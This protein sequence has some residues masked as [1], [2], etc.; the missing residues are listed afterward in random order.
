MNNKVKCLICGQEM[1]DLT[2][3]IFRKHG[4]KAEQYRQQFPNSQIRCDSLL[5]LQS[6]RISGDK[7]PAYQHGGKYSPFSEKFVGGTENI[8]EAKKKA[9]E[10]KT[11]DKD[12][13]QLEYWITKTNGDV[14]QAKKLLTERQKTFSL[15]ICIDKYGEEKGK[16]VW[17]NRQEKWHKNYKKSNFSKVSQKL[18]WQM[19]DRLE[20]LENIYFAELDDT[21]KLDTS[22]INHELRLTLDEKVVLPD[23]I[24]V[25]QKK[26]IEFDGTYWHLVK[27]KKYSFHD[28][29]DEKRKQILTKNGYKSLHITEHEYKNDEQGTIDKCLNFLKQ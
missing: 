13:T 5:E 9:K 6:K 12:N 27:N 11:K 29:P 28:H 16:Q 4:I 3:H 23:F 1:K 2:S 20:S 19:V 21:K 24:D 26:I 17:L 14:E 10:N 18:F 22:G 7:N 15:E 8:K 25:E